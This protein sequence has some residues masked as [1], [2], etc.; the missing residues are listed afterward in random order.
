MKKFFVVISLFFIVFTTYGQTLGS[1]SCS[2]LDKECIVVYSSKVEGYFIQISSGKNHDNMNFLVDD[3]NM[4]KFRSALTEARNKYAEWIE[5]AKKN[6]VT[7]LDKEMDISFPKGTI[8]WTTSEARFCFGV[9]PKPRFLVKEGNYS[10]LLFSGRKVTASDNEY[11]DE[12]A[13]WVFSSVSEVDEL[14]ELISP[15]ALNKKKEQQQQT[16]DL[17]H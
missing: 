6:N 16:E 3:K 10:F 17:F 9:A 5:V 7:K 8:C 12:E 1:Y 2:F 11:I 13:Y 15:D 14:L 4:D